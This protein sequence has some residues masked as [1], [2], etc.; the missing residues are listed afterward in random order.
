MSFTDPTKQGQA[1]DLLPN[2]ESEALAHAEE[3]QQQKEEAEGIA[4][5]QAR[6]AMKNSEEAAQ[7]EA[8]IKE[9]DLGFLKI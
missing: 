1:E 5:D 9:E 7:P 6:K 3:L 8:L 4:F 2:V